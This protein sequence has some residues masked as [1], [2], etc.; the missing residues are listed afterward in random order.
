MTARS[1]R[2]RIAVAGGGVA[3][4]EL[5]LALHHLAADRVHVT[6]VSPDPHFQSKALRTSQPF[7]ADH[8][9]R[10][11]LCDLADELGAE[12]MIDS[13]MAVDADRHAALL[14]SGELVH[15]D[16]LVLATGARHCTAF[17]R[18]LTFTGDQST[19]PFNDLLADL[20][21]HWTHSVAFVVPP[22]MTW[23]LPLYELAIM[24]SRAVRGM[25]IDDLRIQ[26]VSPE[27]MPLAVFGQ[28]ASNAVA[29]LLQ[30]ANIDFRG[31]FYARAT[32]NGVLELLPGGELLDAERVVTLPIIEGPRLAGV[33][34][35]EH[36]FIPVD[37][38]GRVHGLADVY[39]AGDGTTFPIKQGGIACQL[40]DAIAEQLAARA[41]ADL[42]PQ[43]FRPVLRGRLLTG[44][45]A[46]YLE[47]AIPGGAGADPPAARQLWSASRKVHGQYLSPWLDRLD[48]APSAPTPSRS[49]RFARDRS[50]VTALDRAAM[51]LDPYS[52]LPRR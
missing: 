6:I 36:G 37:D 35:D 26:F 29:E 17:S 21:E 15:Y 45:G 43:P 50:D 40:A 11:A 2:L 14:S 34:A 20:E 9:R 46:Q 33:P 12:L 4:I 49:P 27:P 44:H 39:A 42:D 25:A 3:G 7:S 8:M 51:E 32:P 28:T 38:R 52:P 31:A 47:H 22:G 1:Q 16:C 48:R 30:Q 24:T 23:P 41:G 10:H 13:V 5:A 18:A 19:L